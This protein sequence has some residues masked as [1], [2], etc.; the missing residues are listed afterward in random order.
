MRPSLYILPGH[1]VYCLCLRLCVSETQPLYIRHLAICSV[2]FAEDI[3]WVRPSLYIYI[4]LTWSIVQLCPLK[5]MCKWDPA[6]IYYSP[7][8]LVYCLCLR[9]CVSETQPLYIT[10]PFG[11]LSLLKTMCQWDLVFIYN[12]PGHLV[13]CLCLRLCVSET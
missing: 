1:L 11:L 4:L 2:V 13:Y 6:F 3:V 5:T 9:L 10:W 7:S 8:H 12:S